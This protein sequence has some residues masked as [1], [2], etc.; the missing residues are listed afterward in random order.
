[1]YKTTAYL[2]EINTVTVHVYVGA[3]FGDSWTNSLR[4]TE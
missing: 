1:M 4:E 2:I 3:K